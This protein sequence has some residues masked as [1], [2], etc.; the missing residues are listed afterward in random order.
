MESD[1]FSGLAAARNTD[2]RMLHGVTLQTGCH[3]SR[4]PWHYIHHHDRG[5]RTAWAGE[6]GQFAGYQPARQTREICLLKPSWLSIIATPLKHQVLCSGCGCC[7]SV[8]CLCA[9][10][11]WGG[12]FWLICEP[13]R[14]LRLVR[15]HITTRHGAFFVF[16][17][18]PGGHLACGMSLITLV[19]RV[20]VHW[21]SRGWGVSCCPSCQSCGLGI[22]GQGEGTLRRDR[23]IRHGDGMLSSNPFR[24]G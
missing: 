4:F 10:T 6:A 18:I 5:G 13:G 17:E 12:L 21:A 11:A 2:F 20:R 15:R 24:T 3:S 1:I 23:N 9:L 14:F 16:R 7:I 22:P 8:V 19:Q